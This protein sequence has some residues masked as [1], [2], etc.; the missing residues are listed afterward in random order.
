[1]RIE[2][3]K[4]MVRDLRDNTPCD[5]HSHGHCGCEKFD[6]IIDAID[7]LDSNDETNKK[8]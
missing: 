6:E 8:L 7:T 2:E 1:M 3:L 5:E 4:Q